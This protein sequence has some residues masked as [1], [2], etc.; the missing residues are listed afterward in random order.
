MFAPLA[1]E[2]GAKRMNEMAVRFGFNRQPS[3]H[4]AVPTSVYPKAE[5]LTSDL[6]LGVT[7]IGQGGVVATPLQMASVAQVIAGG[8]VMHPPYVAQLPISGSDREPAHRV[9]PPS[10]AT[11]VAQMMQA[12]VA[13]GTGQP[14]QSSLA[15]VA[16]KTGTAEL[17]P[18]IKSDAWFIGYAPAQAPQVVVA[19]LIVHGGV[20][21]TT[22]APIARQVID[23]ALQNP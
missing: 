2:V 14:A 12:V 10:V 1:V 20:G 11:G 23:A 15:T 4:Y 21:G 8:G 18:G 9:I 17:G 16:G 22:A 6:Q 3:I 5:S 7:G 19:V 13:Y